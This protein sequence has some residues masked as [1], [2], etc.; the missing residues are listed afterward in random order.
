MNNNQFMD[1]A[2]NR[3][4]MKVH[5]IFAVFFLFLVDT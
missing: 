3:D 2:D 4:K 1:E 5:A